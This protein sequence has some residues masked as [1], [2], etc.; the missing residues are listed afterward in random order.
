MDTPLLRICLHVTESDADSMPIQGE[1]FILWQH[2]ILTHKYNIKKGIN[3]P[4][5][6]ELKDLW[7]SLVA[8]M[9]K[10]LPGMQKTQVQSQGQE[11]PLEKGMAT[12]SGILTLRILWSEEPVR[13]L[14]TGLQRVWCRFSA[15][16]RQKFY[17]MAAHNNNI[18]KRM[19]NRSTQELRDLYSTPD[20]PGIC[21]ILHLNFLPSKTED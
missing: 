1:S 9:I 4:S 20:L 21:V 7:A 13:L 17:C 8:Q 19:N 15:N 16:S 18:F 10:N 6:Q 3:N 2:I 12:H 11:D 5:T 14:S